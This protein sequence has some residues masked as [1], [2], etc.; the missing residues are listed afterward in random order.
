MPVM[1]AAPAGATQLPV[2]VLDDPP[3]G[4]NAGPQPDDADAPIN[5]EVIDQP[6]QAPDLSTIA[7]PDLP[8]SDQDI[9]DPVVYVQN[10]TNDTSDKVAG[11]DLVDLTRD[12]QPQQ[13]SNSG[14]NPTSDGPS[15][16]PTSDGPVEGD[17][18]GETPTDDSSNQ[19]SSFD[20]DK[21][22]N[23]HSAHDASNRSSDAPSAR[24]SDSASGQSN[25]AD[26]TDATTDAAGAPMTVADESTAVYSGEV[27]PLSDQ[28]V[29]SIEPLAKTGATTSG[30]AKTGLGLILGGVFLAGTGRH[31]RVRPSRHEERTAL[32]I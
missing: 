14:E 24:D 11:T 10:T 1:V 6:Q 17:S 25:R 21:S 5:L 28:T 2:G 20:D 7:D 23:E 26:A 27:Q 9:T 19:T 16:D 13:E 22:K 29:P 15:G 18:S 4:D 32:G 3:P 31:R 30:I 12:Q 8:P